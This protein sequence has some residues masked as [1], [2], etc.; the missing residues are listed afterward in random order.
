M[1][2]AAIT[3]AQV[4]AW[5]NGTAN[6]GS[7][8]WEKLDAKK[9]YFTNIITKEARWGHPP[10]VPACACTPGDALGRK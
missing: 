1:S 2:S 9:Y 5:V 3:D 10:H 6:G 7:S 8:S 4:L